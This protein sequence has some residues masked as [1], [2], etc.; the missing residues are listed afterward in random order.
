MLLKT[1]YSLNIK[2]KG[3]K[4]LSEKDCPNYSIR[5]NLAANDGVLK[6]KRFVDLE[7]ISIHMDLPR[8]H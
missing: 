7:W 1:R 3:P 6:T 4:K 5:F 8:V 2:C